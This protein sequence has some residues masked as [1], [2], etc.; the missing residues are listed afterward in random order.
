MPRAASRITLEV[1]GV[2]VE[3]V[4]DISEADATAE[5]TPCYVCDRPM[6]GRSEDDCHCFHR[7]A[8]AS[9]YRMLWESINGAGSWDANPWVWVIEFRRLP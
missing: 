7:R 8:A 9:D 4:Q 1:T 5:G 2:R 3:R 6:D